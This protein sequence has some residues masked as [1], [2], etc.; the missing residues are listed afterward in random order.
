[1]KEFTEIDSLAVEIWR[2]PRQRTIN[3]RVRQDGGLRVTCGRRVP[4]SEI[5]SF[6]RESEDFIKRSLRKIA[7]YRA[8]Y[9]LKRFE[10]GETFFIVAIL[11]L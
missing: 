10:S 6:I 11:I 2:R 1:M 4:N 7:E 5:F 8:L 3:L 9:P